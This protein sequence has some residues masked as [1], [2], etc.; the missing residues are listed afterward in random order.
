MKHAKQKLNMYE[1]SVFQICIQGV[2]EASLADYFGA[3]SIAAET[4]MGGN[5]VTVITT[6]PIDQGGLVGVINHLNMLGI[7]VISIWLA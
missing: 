5:R 7:P 4:D 3:Q 2:L 6:E 1:P